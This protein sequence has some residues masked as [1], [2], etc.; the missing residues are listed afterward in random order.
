MTLIELLIAMSIM[1]IAMAI[2]GTVLA[3]VQR[4][5]VLNDRLS[6]ANDQAR[7]AV[8]QLDREM[9]SGNVI[10]DPASESTPYFQMRVWTQS[11]YTSRGSAYCELWQIQSAGQMQ[12]RQWLPGANTWLAPWRTVADDIVNRSAGVN[13]FQLDP[14]PLKGGRTVNIHLLVNTDYANHPERT[15]EIQVALTG[16][17]TSYNYPTSICQTLPVAS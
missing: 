7:L 2:F 11:N 10:Y 16:R 12:V 4:S 17:N 9:R 6:Q 5:V 8:E 3:S 1:G 14:D 13:A 15:I